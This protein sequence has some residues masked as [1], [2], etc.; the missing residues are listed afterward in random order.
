MKTTL[1]KEQHCFKVAEGVWGLKDILVNVYFVANPDL[2]WVLVDT[3][4]KTG[5]RKIKKAAAELFGEGIPPQAIVLTHGHFDHVGSL[6]KLLSDWQVPV[7]AHFLELPYLSGKS[8][9]PPAD[10]T[11]GG[12]L[13]ASLSWMY[14]N[15]PINVEDAVKTLPVTHSV[16]VLPEWKYFHT[17]G[18]APGH[19]SL[20]REKDKLLIAG[21]ALVTTKQE[22]ALCV[23]TQR[24][25]LSG[26]PKYFTYDWRQSK[27][28]VNL[29]AELNPQIVAS[30]H[31]KVLT[32]PELSQQL[33]HL[34]HHFEES[35]VPKH[36]RYVDEPAVTN[37]DG[38]VYLPDKKG[39]DI[40]AAVI[41]GFAAL[42][43]P[44]ALFALRRRL[45]SL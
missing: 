41:L 34:A 4:L 9:Y 13:M 30:G 29:L 37:R 36:G 5:Y 40:A 32:G 7:W 25:V 35:A 42:S 1:T 17:P 11:V 8:S 39:L 20:W 6:E 15:E 33:M 23:A 27:D 14:P 2:S 18:H 3:G 28:S 26:P 24:K 21:D 44:L 16:P 10:P 19:I 22:S 12:G 43:I 45:A 38:V 31:G